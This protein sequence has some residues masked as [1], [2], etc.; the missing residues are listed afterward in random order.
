MAVYVVL[1][2]DLN[3]AVV[4]SADTIEATNCDEARKQARE[5]LKAN[6][7]AEGFEIWFD[8]AKVDSWFPGNGASARN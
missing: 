3:D 2:F 4:V 5:L 1:L 8:G 6:S 7:E